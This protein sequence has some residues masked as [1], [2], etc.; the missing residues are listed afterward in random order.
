MS[1]NVVRRRLTDIPRADL[2]SRLRNTLDWP[3]WSPMTSAVIEQPGE[4]GPSSPGEIRRFRSG[5]TI[6]REQVLPSS[7]NVALR[8]RLLEG[9]PLR[10]YIGQVEIEDLGDKRQ[11][12]W[13]SRFDAPFPLTGWIF[14][15]G[16]GG[17]FE[18][19]LDGLVDGGQTNHRTNDRPVNDRPGPETG[20]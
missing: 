8:Y 17:F 16:M 9:L 15:A 6:G 12:T 18:R 7:G 3:D 4:D 11:I 5:R 2:V 14:A 10:N 1:V 20:P 19:L 13:S